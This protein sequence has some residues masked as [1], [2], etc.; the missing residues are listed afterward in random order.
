MTLAPRIEA[1]FFELLAA[2]RDG[3]IEPRQLA[4]LEELVLDSPEAR[5]L[6]LN[7]VD[8]CAELQ[9]SR[10][11]KQPPVPPV[12]AP[13]GLWSSL[14]GYLSNPTTIPILVAALFMGCL[15][16]VLAIWAAPLYRSIAR[17]WESMAQPVYVAQLTGQ[18]DCIWA[19]GKPSPAPGSH[20]AVGRKLELASGLIEITF[21][22]GARVVVEG[23]ATLGL[24]SADGLSMDLGQLRARVPPQAVGFQV[25]TPTVTITDLGTEFGLRVDPG[26]QS[27]VHVFAGRVQ[28]ELVLAGQQGRKPLR[29]GANQAARFYPGWEEAGTIAF[30]GQAF[31]RLAPI[32]P[33]PKSG[34][35]AEAVLAD[36]PIGYW[37]LDETDPTQPAVDLS[38]NKNNGVYTGGVTLGQPSAWPA[39]GIAARFDG[40][41]SVTA[42]AD[43]TEY[44]MKNNFTLEAWVKNGATD[45]QTHRFIGSD[46]WCFGS[47]GASRTLRFTTYWVK[48]YSFSEILP[49]NTWVYLA[50]VLDSDN[51]AS[52]YINGDLVE[53]VPHDQPGH[54]YNSSIVIARGG[55]YETLWLGG[56]DEVA[57]YN[58]ALDAEAIAA[59][60]NAAIPEPSTLTLALLALGLGL[61]LPRRRR[62]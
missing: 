37:R 24:T 60:Y 6:Y 8:L 44:R 36:R 59:H 17:Q 9:W 53:K 51:D 2:M 49:L 61:L 27:E 10:S 28:A 47:V 14:A 56:I 41:G 16:T 18:Q 48:D 20:L 5:R 13:G 34:S 26:G 55:L 15:L 23:P 32:G 46:D 12:A 35:Y 33:P 7:Y 19:K 21:D 30:S 1:E 42:T 25:T 31:A 22:R 40:T 38:R 4:R 57:I 45:G 39:L 3:R 50:V 54:A 11:Q 29:L 52:L 62:K 58:T 43:G